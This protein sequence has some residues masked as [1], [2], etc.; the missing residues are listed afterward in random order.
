[1]PE[2]SVT[3][4]IKPFAAYI[5]KP[6]DP[7]LAQHAVK[8][9]FNSLL[10]QSELGR[11]YQEK[12]EAWKE[13]GFPGTSI[14]DLE[15]FEEE[16]EDEDAANEDD[17]NDEEDQ[18]ATDEDDESD[19]KQELEDSDE[20]NNPVQ[21]GEQHLDPRAGRVDVVMPI[22]PFDAQEI[23]SVLEEEKYKKYTNR[24]TRQLISRVVNNFSTYASGKFPLGVQTIKRKA[25]VLDLPKI[26]DKVNEIVNFEQKLY[27]QN[28]PLKNLSKKNRRKYLAGQEVAGRKQPAAK[29]PSAKKVAA[30]HSHGDTDCCD[31]DH[32]I[33]KK[34]RS[35][36]PAEKQKVNQW[37]E[38][39]IVVAASAVKPAVSAGVHESGKKR[40]SKDSK[41]AAPVSTPKV[42]KAQTFAVDPWD[43]P[44]E[45]GEVEFTTPS[46]KK[47]LAEICNQAA[48]SFGTKSGEKKV[49]N[50]VA[51]AALRGKYN[52]HSPTPATPVDANSTTVGKLSSGEKR[53]KIMLKMNRSQETSEYLQQLRN[54]PNTP[55][56]ANKKPTK[57]LLK[58]NLMPSPINPYYIRAHGLKFD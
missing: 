46:R 58:P 30:K 39:D 23:I 53:V 3:A 17:K 52:K 51:L 27:A 42:K 15:Q 7:K 32:D 19:E 1:M 20:D 57:G 11:E 41:Q 25:D 36:T 37:Q 21:N 16:D 48:L 33:P 54:S 24:K 55:Y 29:Q 2:S 43:L 10:F 49:P 13:L 9:I 6:R 40:K 50:P 56:D 4:L 5:A 8:H 26:D 34:R 22:L 12:F 38:E 44:L 18:D 35:I 47:K 31:H 28:E 14:D 45:D